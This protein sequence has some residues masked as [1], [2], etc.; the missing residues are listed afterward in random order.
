MCLTNRIARCRMLSEAAPYPDWSLAAC[1]IEN[2]QTNLKA[3]QPS[4]RDLKCLITNSKHTWLTSTHVSLS[5][6]LSQSRC[7]CQSLWWF[8]M[9]RMGC[10]TE[11]V[12]VKLAAERRT[13][14][15]LQAV[16][17]WGHAHQS[18]HGLMRPSSTEIHHKSDRSS[19][20]KCICL[21]TW[22]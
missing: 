13:M 17:T 10:S 20:N 6:R 8:W 4:A 15:R 12:C 22:Q 3:V 14:R 5:H 16:H 18:K 9:A 21:Y 7:F 1:S 2:S 19:W 11:V